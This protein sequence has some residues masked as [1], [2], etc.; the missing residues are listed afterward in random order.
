MSGKK[1][2]AMQIEIEKLKREKMDLEA[3]LVHQYHF[4][5]IGVGK[6]SIEHMGGSSVILTLTALGG[7]EIVAPVAIKC[8]LSGETIVALKKDL[9][10]SYEYANELTPSLVK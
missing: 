5:S 6:A 2:L 10:R 9:Y 7:R 8:G 1:K 4:A 3:Q